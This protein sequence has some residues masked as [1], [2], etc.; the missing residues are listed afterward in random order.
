MDHRNGHH[1]TE[2]GCSTSK[3]SGMSC[4][5]GMYI[6]HR[7]E[8]FHLVSCERQR[9]VLCHHVSSGFTI[10]QN[11]MENHDHHDRHRFLAPKLYGRVI[12]G[13]RGHPTCLLDLLERNELERGL[14]PAFG[15]VV[16]LSQGL[17]PFVFSRKKQRGWEPFG[18]QAMTR[19]S[20]FF[21]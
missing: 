7:A 21:F 12:Q 11:H 3:K 17:Q 4:H 5:H 1:V 13:D 16:F 6:V 14:Q 15:A 20:V 10:C 9:L 2:H 18:C 8:L 19:L